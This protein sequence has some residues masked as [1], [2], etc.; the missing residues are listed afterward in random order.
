MTKKQWWLAV[1]AAA[2]LALAAWLIFGTT[3]E[4]SYFVTPTKVG[5]GETAPGAVIRVGGIVKPGSLRPQAA[6]TPARLIITDGVQ[7]LAVEFA[8]ELPMMLREGQ[9]AVARGRL[10]DGVLRADQVIPRFD[11]PLKNT[12]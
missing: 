2:S 12:R 1:G 5:A 4:M 10:H 8:G 7:D 11:D 6:G 3:R 9:E